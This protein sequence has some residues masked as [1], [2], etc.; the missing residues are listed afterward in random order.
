L[1][2]EPLEADLAIANVAQFEL[3]HLYLRILDQRLRV[4]VVSGAWLFVVIAP[5]NEAVLSEA[6]GRL[7]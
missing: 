7:K 1:V 5:N 2:C 4:A 6:L 3:R